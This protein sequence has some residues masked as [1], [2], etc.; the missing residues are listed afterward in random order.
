MM[1]IYYI[2]E[3]FPYSSDYIVRKAFTTKTKAVKYL[4]KTLDLKASTKHDYWEIKQ[5]QPVHVDDGRWWRIKQLE[6][7][8]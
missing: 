8:E 2:Q 7:V 6:V 5:N 4:R 1:K 3:G